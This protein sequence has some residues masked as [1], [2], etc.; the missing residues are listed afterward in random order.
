[1]AGSQ[2]VWTP[3]ELDGS[4]AP[5]I[6]RLGLVA[7]H[8]AAA[9]RAVAAR[10]DVQVQTSRQAIQNLVHV[11]QHERVLGH[12]RPAHVFRQPRRGRLLVHE[13]VR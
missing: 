1:M 6:G 12:V 4:T 9:L 5:R 7:D 8:H 13:I 2:S 10:Q 3:G 11:R